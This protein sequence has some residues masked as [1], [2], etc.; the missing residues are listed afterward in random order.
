MLHVG[1][2]ESKGDLKVGDQVTIKA[3]VGF[4]QVCLV[5][6]SMPASTGFVETFYSSKL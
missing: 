2:V 6:V 3:Q 5:I 1:Q 4:K